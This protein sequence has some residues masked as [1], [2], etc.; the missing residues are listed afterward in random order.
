MTAITV[1][2]TSDEQEELLTSDQV[3]QRLLADPMLRRMAAT[4]LLPAVRH[5]GEW[6]F[7]KSDLDAWIDEQKRVRPARPPRDGDA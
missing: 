3:M 4:C 5:E 6:R 7:R 2:M 1:P